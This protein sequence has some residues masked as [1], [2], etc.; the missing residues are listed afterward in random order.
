M[1]DR[2]RDYLKSLVE[3]FRR[4]LQDCEDL[5]VSAAQEVARLHPESMGCP[6]RQFSE[7]MIDLYRGL[8]LKVFIAVAFVDHQWSH[9]DLVLARAMFEHLWGRRLNEEQTREALTHF[10]HHTGLAWDALLNAF[11]RL[12]AFRQ[13]SDQI[14]TMV[15]R[16]A[17]LVAKADGRLAPEE[18][19]QLKWIQAE[20]RRILVRIPLVADPQNSAKP[21][22]A[23]ALQHTD[24]EIA[25]P[26]SL[27]PPQ[28]GGAA[29]AGLK[30]QRLSDKKSC[31]EPATAEQVLEETLKELDGL[32]GLSGIKQEVHGLI[33]YLKMQK[34]RQA[35]DLPQTSI[36]LHSVFTGNP[37][38]GKT[39]VARLL[40]RVFGS[41]G[42]LARG[43]LV[44]TDRSGL[45]A[46][47][48]GQSAPKSHK[49]IDEALDGVLFID[50]AYSLVAERGEDPYGL[51]ALQ[52][53][54]KRMEDNRDR[55]VVV[56]AGYPEPMESLLASNPGLS[57]RFSRYF[58]FPDYTA[59]ELG[60]IFQ[61]LCAKNRYELPA[62]T[63]VKLLL[64][65]QYLLD[66]R[67]EKFGNGRLA[68]NVFEQAIG[69]LANRIMGQVPLT[70]ELLVTLQHDDILM[71][72]VPEDVWKDLDSSKRELKAVCLGCKHV[73]SVPQHLLLEGI[74]CP[75]C[76][77]TFL[78]EW[79]E[80]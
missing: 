2:D 15:I 57:S 24:F 38:T 12:E 33:N 20:M 62:L 45:V 60:R 50:E 6:Q 30:A 11:D 58:N 77:K 36:T 13:R 37:G 41:M 49:K 22:G 40:G 47:Y 28:G 53:L 27:S 73:D 74:P 4:A 66:H 25:A 14:Q 70:R 75:A 78:F 31:L 52:V 67:D 16:I 35:F 39:T 18:E 71:D 59:S 21:V 72:G 68:R 32:I 44:E 46:E 61:T 64:G 23:Q 19:Q 54:L 1:P 42:I 69:R 79:G 26:P 10:L 29:H 48:A 43:H 80:L 56:L 63:R 34:A 65:F 51:E 55:L 8:I 9:E 3:E 7:R 76:R 17:N 5:Y